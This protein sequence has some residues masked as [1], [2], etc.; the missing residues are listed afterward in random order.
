LL[1]SQYQ[2]SDENRRAIHQAQSRG[3]I[4]VLVT[5]RRFAFAMPVARDVGLETPLICHNGALTKHTRTLEVLDY[6]PLSAETARQAVAVGKQ[7]GADMICSYDAEGVGRL[8]F[9]PLSAESLRLRTYM[10]HNPIGIEQVD[11]LLAHINADPIQVMSAGTCDRMDRLEAMLVSGMDGRVTLL[12]TAYPQRNLSILDILAPRCSKARALENLMHREGIR[13][14]EVMAIGDNHNDVEM[15]EF[16]GVGVVMGN[17]EDH[18]KRSH[19]YV[20]AS[21]DE[22]GVA[23]AISHFILND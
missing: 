5:G 10:S 19:F 11:D 22:H 3:V 17:A 16:A 1:D 2:V 13:R 23:E 4:V 7:C 18:I 21:N 8:V 12:K 20:T 14:N 9:E 6:H 15:L